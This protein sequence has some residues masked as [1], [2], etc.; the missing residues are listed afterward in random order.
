MRAANCVA[1]IKLIARGS[2]RAAD[3]TAAFTRHHIGL[4]GFSRRW[5]GADRAC[6]CVAENL[7][8]RTNV[9]TVTLLPDQNTRVACALNCQRPATVGFTTL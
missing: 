7:D 3:R 9:I 2:G 8:G 1:Q 6:T 4:C 5:L